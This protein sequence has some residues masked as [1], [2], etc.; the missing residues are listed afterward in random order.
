M[1]QRPDQEP[2]ALS[3][4]FFVQDNNKDSLI[5]HM[6][7][8]QDAAAFGAIEAEVQASMEEQNDVI[9]WERGLRFEGEGHPSYGAAQIMAVR[10][11]RLP[12][13]IKQPMTK[14]TE[15]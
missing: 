5:V 7:N 6:S 8:P 14:R 15:D 2:P 13:T 12:P 4:V 9:R 3:F 10:V 11:P 1:T